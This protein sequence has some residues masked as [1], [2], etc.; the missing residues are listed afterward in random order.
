MK[1]LFSM[2]AVV[3]AMLIATPQVNAQ[4]QRDIAKERKEV[5]K[6]SKKELNERASKD[7]RKEAK[8]LAKQG[9]VVSPGTLPLE[10]QLDRSYM[11]Q[12]EYDES[13]YPRYIMTDA[14]SIGENY[15]AAKMQA[16][17]LAKQNL[18]GLIQTEI[19]ALVE[20]TV[21]NKQLAAGEA[22]SI[23]ETVSASKNIISQSIGRIL[24]VTE[25]YRKAENKN[26]EV[27]VRV[28]Y[29]H[30]MAM[31]QAKQAIRQELEKKGD[32]L[33]DQLDKVLGF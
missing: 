7:A 2:V 12:F 11:M 13:M 10:K 22:A 16:L 28:A 31:E 30:K 17:E 20:G 15:D 4:S 24:T 33:H 6:L 23:V 27:L 3:M 32:K 9:W 25:C 19:T 5:A 26:T 8:K 29:N 1:K 14:M 18:A 21:A